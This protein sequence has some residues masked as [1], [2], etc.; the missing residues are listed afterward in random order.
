MIYCGVVHNFVI[1]FNSFTLHDQPISQ[2]FLSHLKSYLKDFQPEL[3]E[4]IY[5]T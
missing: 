4:L 2:T 1:V 3:G 5:T